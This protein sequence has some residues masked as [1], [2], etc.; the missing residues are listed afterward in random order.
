MQSKVG[1]N[2]SERQAFTVVNLRTARWWVEE[3]VNKTDTIGYTIL[4]IEVE[5]PEP[6]FLLPGA[7]FATAE[8]ATAAAQEYFANSP[9]PG[10]AVSKPSCWYKSLLEP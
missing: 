6:R 9:V 8:E 2:L 4:F 1:W 5:D 3:C 7:W 10:V